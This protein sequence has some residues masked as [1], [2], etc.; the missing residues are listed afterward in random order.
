VLSCR[1]VTASASRL[2]DGE[3][4]LGERMAVRVHLI[5]CVHCRRFVRQLGVL[6]ASLH[7]RQEIA[8]ALAPAY[9]ARIVAALDRARTDLPASKGVDGR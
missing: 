7:R 4:G 2:V 1:D 8:P 5:V 3:L 9:L 6:V